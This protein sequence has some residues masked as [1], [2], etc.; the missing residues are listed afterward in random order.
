MWATKATNTDQGAWPQECIN[1]QL[2]HA[3]YQL[4][5]ARAV[6]AAGI[7]A[8][9]MQGV[10]PQGPPCAERGSMGCSPPPESTH[11][12]DSAAGECRALLKLRKHQLWQAGGLVH[13]AR[14]LAQGTWFQA[15]ICHSILNGC[16]WDLGHCFRIHMRWGCNTPPSPRSGQNEE[17]WY[18]SA[19]YEG[20]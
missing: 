2:Q 18:F 11:L 1:R 15:R 4:H 8:V 16:E 13:R 6:M 14:D 3:I 5:Q 19:M 10:C 12:A 9:W 20:P 17:L 7:S